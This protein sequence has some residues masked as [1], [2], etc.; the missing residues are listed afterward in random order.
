MRMRERCCLRTHRSSSLPAS[1]RILSARRASSGLTGG[2]PRTSFH[3][4]KS[5]RLC[6]L[7][8][9]LAEES[10]IAL[11]RRVGKSPV[12]LGR[13][14]AGFVGNRLQFALSGVK[15]AAGRRGRVRRAYAGR[16]RQEQLRPAAGGARSDGERGSDRAG[17]DARHQSG[18]D[19]GSASLA[20]TECAA[21]A[22]GRRR[23]AGLR[24]PARDFANGTRNRSPSAGAA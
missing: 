15:S 2:I 3:W 11:L 19:T 20:G 5:C 12:R 21:A 14:I 18:R 1:A 22:P 23:P 7:S 17:S 13:D 8:R 4:S 24:V 9:V 6:G 16:H 10:M